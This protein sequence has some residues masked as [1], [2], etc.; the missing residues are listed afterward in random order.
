MM[1]KILNFCFFVVLL[2]SLC[3]SCA[4]AIDSDTFT[5]SVGWK[6]KLVK[7]GDCTD[8]PANKFFQFECSSTD[9]KQSFLFT[10]ENRTVMIKSLHLFESKFIVIGE[11][12]HSAHIATIYDL[13]ERKIIDEV[14]GYWF[15]ISNK[16]RYMIFKRF[17]PR[18]TP[19]E[20]VSDVVLLYDLSHSPMENRVEKERKNIHVIPAEHVGIPIFPEYN[21]QNQIITPQY[22][23][24]KYWV[25]SPKVWSITD[26]RVAFLAKDKS[27]EIIAVLADISKGMEEID[28]FLKHIAREEVI[29]PDY[30]KIA[31]EEE[32]KFAPEHIDI[33]DTGIMTIYPYQEKNIK[34]EVIS[35][36]LLQYDK[37]FKAVS[38]PLKKQKG[39]E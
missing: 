7:E 5:E 39:Q 2:M 13:V 9:K 14:Y 23:V 24:D 3:S 37:R 33:N 26:N 34:K 17:Y 12:P 18:F 4:N 36:V 1:K 22:G 8:C 20:F 31:I 10:L 15:V 38:S 28:I 19:Q 30:K 32:I 35:N 21:A 25:Y 6:V 11:L 29:V 16:G 27:G